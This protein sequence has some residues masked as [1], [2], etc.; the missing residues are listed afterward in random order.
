MKRLLYL[1]AL[2]TADDRKAKGGF[3]SAI[4]QIGLLKIGE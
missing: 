4:S 1:Y 3:L 2:I